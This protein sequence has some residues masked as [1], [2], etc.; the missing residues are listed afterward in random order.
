LAERVH[1]PVTAG[2]ARRRLVEFVAAEGLQDVSVRAFGE[3]RSLLL[4]AGVRGISKEVLV[5]ALP[6]YMNDDTLVLPLR[7]V[8]TGPG[9]AMFPQLD[10]NLEITPAGAAAA[11]LT[12]E[13]AYR[14]PLGVIG[15]TLDRVALHRVAEA[16]VRALLQ[17]LARALTGDPAADERVHETAEEPS[18]IEE[19][20]VNWPTGPGSDAAPL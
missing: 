5:Q 14:P 9:G 12:I 20:A 10:A 4:R 17:R 16:T 7:W 13:G 8:A 2:M 3:G 15:S 19:L 1:L 11:D 18:R 6:A